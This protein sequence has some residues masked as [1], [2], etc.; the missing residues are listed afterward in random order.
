MN[1]STGPSWQLSDYFRRST[2]KLTINATR[3]TS[4]VGPTT[5]GLRFVVAATTTST[6]T[7]TAT[8]TTTMRPTDI[9]SVFASSASI[10][11]STF[12]VDDAPAALST[13]AS[14]VLQIWDDHQRNETSSA[15]N[16][17]YNGTTQTANDD[18]DD[19]AADASKLSYETG[20]SFMLLLEDF[21]EYFYSSANNSINTGTDMLVGGGANDTVLLTSLATSGFPTNCS[22]TNS[23]C[24][25]FVQSEYIYT[26]ILGEFIGLYRTCNTLMYLF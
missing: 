14:S 17:Y 24:D 21:G 3:S 15:L 7:T 16:D 10:Q 18:A 20:S 5:S 9:T 8:T 22:I 13:D 12:T 1:N 23:T 19:A 25:D 4:Y 11:Q 2:N 26:R 6:S